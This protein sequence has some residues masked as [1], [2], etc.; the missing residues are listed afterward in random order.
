MRFILLP[1]SSASQSVG[2]SRSTIN[3]GRTYIRE[4]ANG[5]LNNTRY[6]RTQPEYMP[7]TTRKA[8]VKKTVKQVFLQH[9]HTQTYW[10]AKK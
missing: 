8:Q 5:I 6:I 3:H 10:R 7:T 9:K 1:S 4:V 2:A